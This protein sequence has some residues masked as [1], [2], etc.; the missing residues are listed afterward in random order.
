[1]D[2][3]PTKKQRVEQPVTSPEK[4]AAQPPPMTPFGFFASSPLFQAPP[5]L[6]DALS[7]AAKLIAQRLAPHLCDR[8]TLELEVRVGTFTIDGQRLMQGLEGAHVLGGNLR[9]TAT[10]SIGEPQY[11][12]CL[13]AVRKAYAFHQPRA[14]TAVERSTSRTVD[15]RQGTQRVTRAPDG[16]VLEVM[17]KKRLFV[18]DIALPQYRFDL[19]FAANTEEQLSTT[20]AVATPTAPAQARHKSRESHVFG[21]MRFDA[22]EVRCGDTR[23]LEFEVEATHISDAA[24]ATLHV[25]TALRNA[26]ALVGCLYSVS[27]SLCLVC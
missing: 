11:H 12:R 25:S 19:R 7:T 8:D 9:Y 16:A 17:R 13:D 3:A 21:P 10:M 24:A 15:E 20:R 26:A 27:D 1:M 4:L 22:T 2:E 23:T 6:Q 18:V 5:P 14:G